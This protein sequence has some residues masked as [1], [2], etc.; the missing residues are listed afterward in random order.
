MKLLSPTG[1]QV[2]ENFQDLINPEVEELNL[3]K[4]VRYNYEET[5]AKVVD[6]SFLFW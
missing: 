6:P 2:K 5:R 1:T 4:T 3:R